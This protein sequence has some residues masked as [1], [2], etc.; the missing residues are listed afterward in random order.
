MNAEHTADTAAEDLSVRH[1]ADVHRFEAVTPDGQ[2]AGYLAYD[3]VPTHAPSGRGAFVAVHTVVEP[4]HAG[5]GVGSAL[6]RAAL[7]HAR[8]EHLVV[9]PECSFVRAFIDKHAEYQDLLP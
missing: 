9:I 4:D 8:A 2:V 6:A 1:N 5:A 7:D 3:E